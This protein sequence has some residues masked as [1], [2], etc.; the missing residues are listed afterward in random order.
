MK[1]LRRAFAFGLVAT[2]AACASQTESEKDVTRSKLDADA[3]AALNELTTT[4][5]VARNLSQN[6][7]GILVFPSIVSGSF[8]V[9]AETGNGVMFFNG[10]PQEYYNTS[11]ISFGFQAG[12]K[13]YSQV[14]MFMTADALTR[15]RSSEGF[16]V[17]VDGSITVIDADMA[18]S[19]DTNNLQDDIVAF[20]FSSEGL[21]GG[22]ALDGTKYTRKDL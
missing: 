17:G 7:D 20:I 11:G 15:F 22:V 16:E 9:G 21:A 1:I 6:A 5:P 4:N 13:A 3:R 8:L 19:L 2:L 10:R 18:K 12:A 14:I